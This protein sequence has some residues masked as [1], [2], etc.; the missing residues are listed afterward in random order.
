MTLGSMKIKEYAADLGFVLSGISAA[1][2]VTADV[3][4]N[5]SRY[6]SSG[7]HARMD[8]LSR[9][10]EKRF[11]VSL[12][13]Q[14][15]K[16]VISCAVSYNDNCQTN[17][18]NAELYIARYA[19][20]NDYH[21]TIR[22]RLKVLAKRITEHYPQKPYMRVFVDT[23]P[24]LE[25]FYAAKA[26]LGWIGKNNLLINKDYG[27]HLLLGEIVIDQEYDYDSPAPSHCGDCSL[28]LD[29]CPG[30]AISTGESFNANKCLSYHTIESKESIPTPIASA[31]DNNVFGCD[32]CQAVCPYNR[33]AVV[34]TDPEFTPRFSGI[35]YN[36]LLSMNEETFNRSF[37]G[38]PLTRAGLDR[39][40]Y[41]AQTAAAN[42]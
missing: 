36:E 40:Q 21:D 6:I 25:K 37:A 13:V 31:L 32:V 9:N 15:S 8:Y 35:E 27:S 29:S 16:S 26:G 30:G 23:A 33:S 34:N 5:Y 42:R 20:F 2:P 41:I 11:D 17:N 38:T 10:I 12:L 1:E 28:C 3:A 22:R 19:R 39:L 4:I 24:L 18:S 7:K 14:G